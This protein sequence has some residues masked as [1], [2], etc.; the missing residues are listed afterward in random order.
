MLGLLGLGAVLGVVLMPTLRSHL[1]HSQTLASSAI[2]Y[3][4]G[5]AGAVLA[6]LPVCLALFV[7][8]GAAWIATLTTL[9]AALQL[10]LPGWVRARGMSVY[11]L[12]FMGGQGVASF[13]WGLTAQGIGASGCFLVAAGLLV[14]TAGSVALLPLLPETGT[15]D[16][17]IAALRSGTPTLVFSPDPDDGPVTIAVTYQVK[18]HRVHEFLSAMAAVERSRR[19]T[20]ASAWRLERSGEHEHTYRE[21]FVVPSWHEYTRAAAERWTGFDR[22]NLDTAAALSERAPQQEHYFPTSTERTPQ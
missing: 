17:T 16:R 2:A 22:T 5:T 21:E 14:L 7:L 12:V 8:T 20:G 3:A 15:L 13:V 18:P 10:T 6:P 19:R 1:S 9:N 4:F 11:L